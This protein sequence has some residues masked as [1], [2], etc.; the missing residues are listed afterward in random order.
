[1]VL[2]RVEDFQ[3]RR[4]GVP[5][6]VAADLVDLVEH[7]DRVERAGFFQRASDAPRQ[8]ADIRSA[9][10]ANLGLVVDAAQRDAGER[11]PERA[12]DRLAK[13]GLADTWRA[14]QGDDR[15]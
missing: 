9:M 6:P 11:A 10:A 13:R 3:Q 12:S 4:R 7:D 8:R 14:D 15:A 1:M 5:A 2:G